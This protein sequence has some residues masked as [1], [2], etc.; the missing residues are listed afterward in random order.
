MGA[1]PH[2]T[3]VTATL[4]ALGQALRTID[5]HVQDYIT[6]AR[7]TAGELGSDGVTTPAT[8]IERALHCGAMSLGPIET[9]RS[10]LLSGR[11]AHRR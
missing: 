9:G 2:G 8:P 7:M 5:G 3:V 11:P 6:E 4:L 10:P 1:F